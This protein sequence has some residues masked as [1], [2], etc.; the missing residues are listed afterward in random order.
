MKWKALAV[1]MAAV[2]LPCLLNAPAEAQP[3]RVFVSGTGSDNNA[4]TIAKPCR[5]FQQAHDTVAAFGEIDALDPA[6]YG[7]LI[8]AKAISIQGYGFAGIT[9]SSGIAITVNAPATHKINL[10]GLLID[11]AGSGGGGIQ[12]NTG[13]S[14][15]VQ[16]SLIR[17]INGPG[18]QVRPSLGTSQLFVSDSTLADNSS[19]GIALAPT[20]SAAVIAVV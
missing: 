10:S 6:I 20:G 15:N 9:A 16:H 1:A 11:G 13:A 8:I 18:I 2:A 12:F 14:L 3:T 7:T 19:T 4:C 17:G 5:T